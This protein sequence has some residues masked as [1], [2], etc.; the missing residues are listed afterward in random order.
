VPNAIQRLK[1]QIQI[2]MHPRIGRNLMV[3][4]LSYAS[5][6]MERLPGQVRDLEVPLQRIGERVEQKENREQHQA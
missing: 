5:F 6:T 1:I 3:P 2:Q 4:F